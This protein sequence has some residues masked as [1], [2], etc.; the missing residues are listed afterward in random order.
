MWRRQDVARLVFEE[1]VVVEVD[2][3]EVDV[4]EVVEVDVVDVVEVDVVEGWI[5]WLVFED[6]DVDMVE[7]SAKRGNV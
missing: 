4:V 1:E 2:V 6:V 7:V 3:V 5:W